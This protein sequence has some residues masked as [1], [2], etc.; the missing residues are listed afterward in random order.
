[1]TVDERGKILLMN[2]SI[3]ELP[4]DRAIGRNSLALMPLEF[5]RW[6]RRALKEV[7]QDAVT[8]NF[9]YSTDEGVYWEGRI[10]PIRADGPVTAAMVIATDVTE[11]R[12][13]EIQSLRNA[14]LA[15]IGVLAAGVAHEINN[16]NNAIQFNTGLVARAWSDITPILEEYYQDNGDFALGGLSFSEARETLPKLLSEVTRNTQRI[17]RI[18]DNLKHMA[19][20]DT[21]ELAEWVDIQQVLQA[22]VMLLHNQIQKH[23]DI[24]NLEVPDDLPAVKGNSQQLEQVF[25][26]I[27]LNA[28]QSLPD[29]GRGVFISASHNPDDQTLSIR[30]RDEGQGVS[31]RNIGR[32]TEP[33]FT[34]RSE[35][36][37]TG[38][39]LSISR[40]IIEKHGGNLSFESQQGIGTTVTIRLP[41]HGG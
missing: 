30:I 23:T 26:N 41:V 29:R 3:P 31:D 15:S 4:A 12:N 13:L 8:R 14:R 7:F 28:L 38:L 10:V 5:R 9:Q 32:L 40:S 36:G 2:R 21:G 1:M 37:G 19:R 27:L 25:I 16:P 20:Q 17:K 34:T 18:V 24:C 11:K 6:Y 33:F 22:T 39:G 35:N